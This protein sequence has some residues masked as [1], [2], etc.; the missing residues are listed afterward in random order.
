MTGVGG[1]LERAYR[2]WLETFPIF[3]AAVIAVELTG[4]GDGWSAWGAAAYLW[5]RLL[6]LPLYAAGVPVLRGLV[7]NVPT[8]GIIAMFATLFPGVGG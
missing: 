5:G 6:Y 3:I 1:R 7:W 4:A 2:N 8:L